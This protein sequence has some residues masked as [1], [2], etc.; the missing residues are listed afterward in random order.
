MEEVW[1]DIPGYIVSSF[2]RVVSIRDKSA[3]KFKEVIHI[4]KGALNPN[5]YKFV[6]LSKNGKVRQF[7]IHRLVMESFIGKSG[8]DVNLKDGNK[9]NNCLSNLGYVSHAENILHS[10]RVLKRKPV[11]SWLGKSGFDHN[12]SYPVILTNI[13]NKRTIVLGS[14][15]EAESKG[16]N[17]GT[18]VRCMKNNT[19]YNNQYKV[20]KYGNFD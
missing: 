15:R 1:K 19:L 14:L 7:S 13:S 2:G 4:M 17:R 5:G 9:E 3:H 8:K 16:F 18:L 12:K 11:K 6:V 20:E 10:F